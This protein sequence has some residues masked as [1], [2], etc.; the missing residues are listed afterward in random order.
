MFGL[1]GE[2]FKFLWELSRF[3]WELFELFGELFE[4]FGELFELF[5]ELFELFELFGELF[6]LFGELF[7]EL[8]ETLVY[9]ML[10]LDHS[11]IAQGPF[12]RSGPQIS[13]MFRM[14]LSWVVPLVHPLQA[15]PTY[16]PTRQSDIRLSKL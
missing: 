12:L 3:V 13:M 11:H 8:F 5:G 4:L 2:L 16:Q 14:E 7:G 1:I 6:E 15:M 9:L 10:L